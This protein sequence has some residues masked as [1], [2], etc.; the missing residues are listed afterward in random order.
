MCICMK[1]SIFQFIGPCYVDVTGP[2]FTP[3]IKVIHSNR[4][5]IVSWSLG[6]FE[7]S[8]DP[9]PLAYEYAIGEKQVPYF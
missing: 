4:H 8:E 7:D 9:Y 5:L 1:I 2:M 6:S 3:P